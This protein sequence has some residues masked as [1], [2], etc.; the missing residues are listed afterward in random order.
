MSNPF[1]DAISEQVSKATGLESGQVADLLETP[2]NP[3]MG[4]YALPCFTLAKT[5][6]KAPNLI[7]EELSDQVE[8]GGTITE[9]KPAGPYLNFFVSKSDLVTGTMARVLAE[10]EQYGRSKVG[11]GK[12][13]VV[14]FSSPN[15]AKP[16]TIGHLRTTAI[17]NSLVR[18]HEALGWKVVGVNYLGDWGAPHGMNIAAYKAWGDEDKVRQNPPYELFNLYV[19]FNAEVESDPSLTESAQAWTRNLEAGDEEALTLWKWFRE[20]TIEDFKRV[21][22]RMGVEFSDYSG[23]SLYHE[24][25]TRLVEKLTEDGLAVESE[26]A[27]V[28]K[29]DDDMTPAV[30]QTSH[31]T[32]VYLGR[33][34]CAAAD[35]KARYDFDKMLYVVGAEQTRHFKQLF[36]TLK[37]MG[38]DWADNCTHVPFGLINFKGMKMSTR[39][40]NVIFLEEVLDRAVELTHEI[41]EEKNPDLSN[42]DQVAKDVGIGAIIYADLDSRR[43]RDVVF[44]W[45]EILNFTGETGP[46]IQ[47]THARYCSVLRKFE[48]TIPPEDVDLSLLSEPE[49]VA[50]VKCLDDYP[51]KIEQ[52]AE[53]HEPSQIA[54]YL[55]DLCTEANRFYTACRVVSEDE[56]LTRARV[57]LVYAIKTVLKSGLGLLGMKAPEEM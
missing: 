26:G 41:I 32:I 6:R 22:R 1:V 13:I 9:V 36:R 45:E 40:G 28:V 15:I 54:T 25:S 7:A 33:D 17:G 51:K 8:V 44:E 39:K 4:D 30:L 19:K 50:V 49:A 20:E 5:M 48:Q 2:P 43:T 55:I 35:R 3:D 31:G 29:F 53:N 18:I 37:M 56:A 38:H 12:T 27:L 16:F 34:L 11:E 46:Y 14:D 47:Y 24:P 42:K 57:T 10:G 21:Y 52:S 23:E